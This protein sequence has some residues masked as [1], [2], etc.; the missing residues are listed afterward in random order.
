MKGLQLSDVNGGDKIVT[1]NFSYQ[2]NMVQPITT[3]VIDSYS[4]TKFTYN[5][6]VLLLI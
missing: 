2:F 1:A 4:S 6:I 3:F 5:L